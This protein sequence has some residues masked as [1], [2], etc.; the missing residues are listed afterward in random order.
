MVG[1]VKV[2]QKKRYRKH[3]NRKKKIFTSKQ[4]KVNIPMRILIRSIWFAMFFLIFVYGTILV[5][6]KTIFSPKYIIKDVQYAQQSIDK[7]DDPYLYNT[8]SSELE[9]KN[10]YMYKFFHQ[11]KLIKLVHS[12]FPLVKDIKIHYQG[13]N[14]V[15]VEVDFFDPQILFIY[16]QQRFW[17]YNDYV[18]N[19]Y[20]WNTLGSES[21]KVKLPEYIGQIEN[22]DWMFFELDATTFTSQIAMIYEYFPKLQDL[23]YLPGAQRTKVYFKNWLIVY[24]NNFKSIEEQLIHFEQLY[25]YYEDFEKIS[26]IDLGSL[27][28]DNVIIK[29]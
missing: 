1:L 22:L 4:I 21:Y 9:N 17:L 13:Y 19:L 5:L 29:K 26:I 16:W 11:N 12:Q 10:F 28:D 27:S 24:F 14:E 20:T 2:R 18:F 8:I 23:L 7:I 6:K 25:K 3:Q 15:A